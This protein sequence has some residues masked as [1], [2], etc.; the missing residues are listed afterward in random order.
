M[1]LRRKQFTKRRSIV[2]LAAELECFETGI[3]GKFVQ[4]RSNRRLKWRFPG[5]ARGTVHT[6]RQPCRN[7]LPA[8]G[9]R[10]LN[11]WQVAM[12]TG[13]HSPFGQKR[14]RPTKHAAQRHDRIIDLSQDAAHTD[15]ARVHD[16]EALHNT[17]DARSLFCP[18]SKNRGDTGQKAWYVG[19]PRESS[20][21]SK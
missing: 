17:I 18:P 6:A 2:Q 16:R 4:Q 13:T 19:R 14:S 20:A 12:A 15:A 8:S 5:L 7:G 11:P 3:D 21:Q 9:T 1:H 10:V